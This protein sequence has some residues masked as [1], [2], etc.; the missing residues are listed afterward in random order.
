MAKD[1]NKLDKMY[2]L[3]TTK[4]KKTK[5]MSKLKRYFL[6]TSLTQALFFSFL[7]R[8]DAQTLPT[9]SC[10]ALLK[11]TAHLTFIPKF[12]ILGRKHIEG[13]FQNGT[14]KRVYAELALGGML[15]QQT[16]ARLNEHNLFVPNGGLCAS[17][18][19]TNV[20]GAASLPAENVLSFKTQSPLMLARLVQEYNAQLNE[21]ARIGAHVDSVA[22][23][24]NSIFHELI[25][26]NQHFSLDQDITIAATTKKEALF[27]N[28]I[29][30]A[31]KGDSIAIGSVRP[32]DKS[33]R[34]AHAIVILGVDY[35][36]KKLIISDP[37]VPNDIL[38][39]PFKFIAGDTEASFGTEISFTVPYTYGDQKVKLFALTTLQ[40]S[41]ILRN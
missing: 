39:V 18:C 27:P 6:L 36:N 33:I 21:D 11:T 1:S 35:E 25:A 9:L 14:T 32:I 12:E 28:R 22:D 38:S 10:K 7:V 30:S 24:A 41:I 37:N 40:R 23:I 5:I 26:L 2:N 13:L 17:T 8:V 29:F 20:L 3:L 19:M 16:D 15:L 31:L 4:T 34:S